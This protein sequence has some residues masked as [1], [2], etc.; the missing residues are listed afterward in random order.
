M[1]CFASFLV[2][3]HKAL[4]HAVLLITS[5]GA[6]LRNLHPYNNETHNLPSQQPKCTWPDCQS[7]RA[8]PWPTLQQPPRGI[9]SYAFAAVTPDMV[10]ILI[11]YADDVTCHC[12]NAIVCR[13][14]R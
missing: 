13:I 4:D 5:S 6:E 3:V 14:Y 11:L 1:I 2:Q 12:S 8:S 7:Q 9:L 10:F